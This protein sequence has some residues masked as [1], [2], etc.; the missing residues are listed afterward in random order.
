MDDTR[1]QS[2]AWA[3]FEALRSLPPRS[4]DETAVSQF[5]EIV[6]AL[7]EAYAIELSSFRVPDAEMKR[8]IVGVSRRGYSGRSRPP[9]MSDKRYCDEQFV[10]RQVEGIVLYFR[11]LQPP[12]E[13]QRLGF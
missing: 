1:K 10:R 7:E 2:L 13:R 4:W 6:T 11:N 5:H 9:Q 3:R 8:S 12:P